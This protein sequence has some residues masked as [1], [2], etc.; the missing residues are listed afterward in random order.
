MNYDAY[1]DKELLTIADKIWRRTRL[2]MG[3]FD[4]PTFRVVFPQRHAVFF[5]IRRELSRRAGFVKS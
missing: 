1:T 4:G 3:S 5:G 2:E